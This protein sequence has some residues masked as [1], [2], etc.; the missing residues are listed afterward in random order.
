MART[1]PLCDIALP[2]DGTP[3]AVLAKHF[4]TCT[5]TRVRSRL[6]AVIK[7]RKAK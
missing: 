1:C 3:V 7:R 6:G 4:P 2:G 5:A